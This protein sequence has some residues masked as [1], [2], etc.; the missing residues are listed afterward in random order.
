MKITSKDH[1]RSGKKKGWQRTGSLFPLG[2]LLVKGIFK[3]LAARELNGFTCFTFT[4]LLD[5]ERCR[6]FS[7]FIEHNWLKAISYCPNC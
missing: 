2:F 7:F 5:V 1:F 6:Q 4:F 3:F